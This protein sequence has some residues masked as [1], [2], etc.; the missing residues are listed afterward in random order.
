[1]AELRE[2]AG[3]QERGKRG[4]ADIHGHHPKLHNQLTV[5]RELSIRSRSH[6]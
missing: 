6:G 4:K 2:C 3:E 1:M 5:Y